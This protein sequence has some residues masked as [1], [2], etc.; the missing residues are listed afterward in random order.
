MIDEQELKDTLAA[1]QALVERADCLLPFTGA[2]I[3]TDAGIPD[4]RS[5]GG[6]WTQNK[7]IPFDAFLASAE[8][9]REAWRRRFAM[10]GTFRQARPRPRPR[11]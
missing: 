11:S 3:S 8:A 10:D 9:R 6:L 2:G 5:P 4:F 7:P 1:F